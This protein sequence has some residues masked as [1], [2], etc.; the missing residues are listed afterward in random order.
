MGKCS[1]YLSMISTL[2]YFIQFLTAEFEPYSGHM[3]PTKMPT[4]EWDPRVEFEPNFYYPQED[5]LWSYCK[6]KSIGWNIAM[7]AAILGAVPDAAMNVCLPLAIYA[8]VCAHLKQPL[9]F[10]GDRLGW[11]GGV[12]QSSAMLNA[13]LEEWA[14]LTE[15]AKDQKFNAVDSSMFTCESFWPRMAGWY[16]IPW[17]GP[18]VDG[19][20]E[21]EYG[22]YPPPRG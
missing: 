4:E 12:S 17:T 21:V 8:S 1:C 9:T 5:C 16:G 15:K 7:P 3:G 10:P 22:Y 13:Y 6:E 14:V 11:Q 20:T 18:N 2:V 19:L